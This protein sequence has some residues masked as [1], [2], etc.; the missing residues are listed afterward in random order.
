MWHGLEPIV[1]SAKGSGQQILL[2]S[3]LQGDSST[4][5]PRLPDQVSW[6]MPWISCIVIAFLLLGR[7]ASAHCLFFSAHAMGAW[8][9]SNFA[10]V[11][12]WLPPVVAILTEKQQPNARKQWCKKPCGSQFMK[13]IVSW[14]GTA[15][16]KTG[17]KHCSARL[18]LKSS[19]AK[20]GTPD[21]TISFCEK[22]LSKA[23]WISIEFDRKM[24]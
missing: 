8:C 13:S 18:F 21:Q 4:E 24:T 1:Q 11:L 6:V 12:R 7:R 3:S 17:S 9:S 14:P 23:K 15:H 2:Y 10:F 22:W 19:H 20:H 5:T 16:L